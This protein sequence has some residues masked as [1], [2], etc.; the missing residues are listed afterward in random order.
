M[1]AIVQDDFSWNTRLNL[2]MLSNEITKLKG[3]DLTPS[4]NATNGQDPTI[5]KVGES[6]NS[7][8]LRGY[9]GVNSENGLAQYYVL[10]NGQR[11]GAITT[12]A[13]E[14][15]FGVFGKALQDVQGGFYNQLT[16]RNLSL[17][18]LFTFGIGGEAYDRT[19]FKRDDDGFAPQF[20]NT[21]H[22]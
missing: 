1:N 5:I 14:A 10:E 19:A 7:F 3:G 4:Y 21:T 20:T 16:Y 2:T 13:E 15:G 22:N 9:A 8:Y 18:F 6:L 11:T 12:N 17:D